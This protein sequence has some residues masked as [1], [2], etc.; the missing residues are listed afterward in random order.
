MS[1]IEVKNLKFKIDCLIDF[2]NSD[3]E[4][5][6]YR[7][8]IR[9]KSHVKEVDQIAAVTEPWVN[10]LVEEGKEKIEQLKSY[11]EKLEKIKKDLELD[12]E[13]GDIDE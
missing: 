6:K 1:N 8:D 2:I 10:L 3:I 11:K 13:F 4:R 9:R 7:I 12:D 5:E